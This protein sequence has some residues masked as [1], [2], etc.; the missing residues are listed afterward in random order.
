MLTSVCS[1]CTHIGWLGRPRWSEEAKSAYGGAPKNVQ[2]NGRAHLGAKIAAKSGV[3]PA[4]I[5]A[6]K[7]TFSRSKP[8]QLKPKKAAD[9]RPKPAHIGVKKAVNFGPNPAHIGAKKA[10]CSGSSSKLAQKW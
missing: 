8:V 2:A 7:A 6:K 10:A 1:P 9:S 4:Q 5:G 3:K